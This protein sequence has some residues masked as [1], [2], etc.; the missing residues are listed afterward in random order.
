MAE[1][2]NPAGDAPRP[3]PTEDTSATDSDAGTLA[4]PPTPARAQGPQL[5]ALE[6][7][8]GRGPAGGG[9]GGS[10]TGAPELAVT[11]A[12]LSKDRGVVANYEILSELGRGG[13]GVVYKARQHRPNRL[14]ALK[15]ILS[16]AHAGADQLARFYAEAE[17]VAGLQH[18]NIVQIYEVDEQD[19]QPY[20]SMEFVEGAGLNLRLAGNP[21]PTRAAAELTE[22]LARAVYYAH[23]R[24][25]VHRDLKPANI[26]L[27][28]PPAAS[29]QDADVVADSAEHLYGVPKISDFGLA[30]RLDGDS[31]HT[32]SGD[33]LGT[34]SYMSPEQ[35]AG[36][37]KQV[38]PAAD[39]WA[40]GAIL[41]EL[42]TGRPPFRAATPVDT[43]WQVMNEEPVPPGR[44][45]PR[46]PRD[47]ETICLKCLH[48][49]PARRYASALELADDLRAFL[50]GAPIKARPAGTAERVWRWCRRNPLPASLLAAVT[51][52]AAFGLWHLSRLSEQLVH[53]AALDSARQQAD[54]LDQVN[55]YYSKVNKNLLDGGVVV[56]QHWEGRPGEMPFPAT[57]TIG[58]GEQIANKGTSGVKVRLYSDY[59]FASR[60]KKSG[61][62]P[63]DEK[64]AQR[65]RGQK[66]PWPPFLDHLDDFEKM[67]LRELRKDPDT[68]VY[69]FEHMDDRPVLRLAT[70]RRLT[71]QSCVNCHNTHLEST[72]KDWK[73]GDVRGV[74]EIVRPLDKDAE[75]IQQGLRGTFTLI[76]AVAG[77]LLAACGLFLL[78]TRR[79][80]ARPVPGSSSL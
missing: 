9:P 28:T 65:D 55:V 54:T 29:R 31:G 4:P 19:G 20:F 8:K 44:L 36:K 51:L 12:P 68:P 7:G 37:V 74:L 66:E 70:A 1:P 6:V 61:W 79:R 13:M 60:K 50:D 2:T 48:K 71:L 75:R 78:L 27:G 77:G 73:V 5:P 35:A 26:L 3:S 62:R 16:G 14:V 49:D 21:Q 10:R 64:M 17:A 33:V 67:A 18:P 42:L 43:L 38:G 80:R 69:R 76:A 47:L 15:M 30:K 25:I 22:T 59:P 11:L 52:G 63:D 53:S 40:L 57:F 58:L 56:S 23:Q 24:G 41:Y 39:V 72:K 32:H 34:P 45:R 46:L